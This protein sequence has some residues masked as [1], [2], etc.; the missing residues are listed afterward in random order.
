M[1]FFTERAR[2]RSI[3]DLPREDDEGTVSIEDL[4]PQEYDDESA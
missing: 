2:R 1:P 4:I 3:L